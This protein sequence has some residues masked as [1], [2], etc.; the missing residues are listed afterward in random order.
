MAFSSRGIPPELYSRLQ[1]V[2]LQCGPLCCWITAAAGPRR[3]F[4]WRTFWDY[5]DVG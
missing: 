2:L 3:A 1:Q 4:V 5:P